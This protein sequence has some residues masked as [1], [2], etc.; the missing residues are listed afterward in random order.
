MQPIYRPGGWMVRWGKGV[1]IPMIISQRLSHLLGSLEGEHLT[2][3]LHY[4]SKTIYTNWY[5]R[6]GQ[7]EGYRN[8]F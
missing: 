3:V 8:L 6:L 1:Y 2:H 5:I 4:L 7:E